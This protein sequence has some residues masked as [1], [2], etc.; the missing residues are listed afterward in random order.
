[1]SEEFDE[2]TLKVPLGLKPSLGLTYEA[3]LRRSRNQLQL[4]HSGQAKLDSLTDERY[5]RG[6]RLVVEND[7]Y[8]LIGKVPEPPQFDLVG[9][10]LD[11]TRTVPGIHPNGTGSRDDDEAKADSV[12]DEVRWD[13]LGS[14]PN[15]MDLD[16]ALEELQVEAAFFGAMPSARESLPTEMLA[17]GVF[18]AGKIA[19]GTLGIDC[20][21]PAGSMSGEKESQ[22]VER[23]EPVEAK[24]LRVDQ[25]VNCI[26][27]SAAMVV[28]VARVLATSSNVV[29]DTRELEK[30]MGLTSSASRTF[31]ASRQQELVVEVDGMP[32]PFV[33]PPVRGVMTSQDV[34]HV[35][36]RLLPT[37]SETDVHRAD[38]LEAVGRGV[39]GGLTTLGAHEVRFTRLDDFQRG[40]LLILRGA[41][42]RLEL[43]VREAIS[44]TSLQ[45]SPALVVDPGNWSELKR[46]A[47]VTLA[48]VGMPGDPEIKVVIDASANM[49]TAGKAA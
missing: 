27:E 15:R 40:I 30:R 41:G 48:A 25:A 32:I 28:E 45:R 9:Y 38:V 26:A 29:A 4:L 35:K 22:R 44:T 36:V 10:P 49:D 8:F 24:R 7:Q 6:A 17:D 37:R 18:V 42:Q 2:P 46:R 11:A 34:V 12:S 1:M 16:A 31:I 23:L 21:G 13:S 5:L 3:L 20:F 39:P 14:I 43:G 33:A 47:I 19:L